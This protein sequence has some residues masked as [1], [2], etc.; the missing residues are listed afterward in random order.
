M[1]KQA[2]QLRPG[3]VVQSEIGITVVKMVEALID[4]GEYV[5]PIKVTWQGSTVASEYPFDR[6]FETRQWVHKRSTD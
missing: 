4:E 2:H 5:G 1:F 3:D 6:E